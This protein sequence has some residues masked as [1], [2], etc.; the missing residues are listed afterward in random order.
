MESPPESGTF[1]L[2]ALV[3]NDQSDVDGDGIGDVCDGDPTGFLLFGTA[4]A[5]VS[6]PSQGNV[7][8]TLNPTTDDYTCVKPNLFNVGCVICKIVGSECIPQQERIQEGGPISTPDS[9]CQVDSSG[10]PQTFNVPKNFADTFSLEDGFR[11]LWACGY[12]N[13]FI[14][15]PGE[16]TF[17]GLVST[18]EQ[19][20]FVGTYEFPG[21]TAP[22]PPSGQ[23]RATRKQGATQPVKFTLLINGQPVTEGMHFLFTQLI[24]DA[25]G[26]PVLNAPEIPATSKTIVGNEIPFKASINSWQYDL[27][28]TPMAIGI[29][30]L[31]VRPDDGS[32]H[33]IEL[34]IN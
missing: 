30:R 3:A 26:T 22:T 27:D 14:P 29:H 17:I 5:A 24:E 25:T 4:T 20:F 19:S 16:P 13:E 18:N 21:F 34:E 6:G 1:I 28:T 2:T 8:V 11:Y 23:P 9:L 31:V 32:V 12:D 15:V 33:N 10:A 7:E